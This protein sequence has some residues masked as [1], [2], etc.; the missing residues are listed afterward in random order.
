MLREVQDGSGE[1]AGGDAS[2]KT[3]LSRGCD[4]V[5]AAKS[6]EFLPKKLG[7][8]KMVMTTDDVAFLAALKELP[9]ASFPLPAATRINYALVARGNATLRSRPERN[10][11]LLSRSRRWMRFS[12]PLA[13]AA[14]VRPSSRSQVQ[15]TTP[16][17][18]TNHRK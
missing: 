17:S 14:S 8:V 7:G 13:P 15:S 16:W 6:A 9:I 1:C 11:S 4:P 18:P 5:M 2:H 10:T 12:S 3:I